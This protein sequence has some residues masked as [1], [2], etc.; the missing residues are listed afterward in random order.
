MSGDVTAGRA[1]QRAATRAAGS[2]GWSRPADVTG[3]LLKRWQRGELW[4][5][6]TADRPA[7]PQRVRIAG[8]GPREIAADFGRV[9]D[10]VRAWEAAPS[11]IRVEYG[12]VG[13]VVVGTNRV[14]VAAWIDR[15]A[16]LWRMLG[17]REE[18][19]SWRRIAASTDECLPRLSAWVRT[20]PREVTTAAAIWDRAVDVVRWI[21]TH[22]APTVHLRHIDVP[23]VDTKFLESNRRLLTAL[24]DEVLPAERVNQARP[25]TDLVGRYHLAAKP[26]LV[27]L[28]RL[29]G[30][31]LVPAW[32]APGAAAAP[33]ELALR[34]GDLAATDI[35][36]STVLVVENE[37]TYLA[38]PALGD[39]IA[40]FGGG[41]AAARLG[42][43]RWLAGRDVVYWG[44]LDTHGF[45]ILDGLRGVL[46][47]VR[48]VLMDRA[49]L[50]LHEAHWGT[51]G[52]PYSGSL[53][54]LDAAERALFVDLVEGRYG[55]RVRLEQERIRFGHVARTLSAAC[56]VPGRS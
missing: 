43:I 45:A 38:L 29:D 50:E 41:Y 5:A 33:S 3:Q 55:E 54:R 48:S 49:T 47:H 52:T 10:W 7:V 23:G 18:I 24:L 36:A 53:D 11:G 21:E 16:D 32:S 30:G 15:E 46:P 12:S 39:T 40:I 37:T 34:T 25:R 13:G 8:P 42:L 20:H 14:P 17:V 19:E 28:R 56:G 9:Q 51:D 27:R 4:A 6:V 35:P 1:R 31:P 26:T 44:D 22:G 2:A